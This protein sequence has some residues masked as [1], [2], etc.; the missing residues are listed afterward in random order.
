MMV[1]GLTG[2][3]GSGKST[4]ADQ[5]AALGVT[6]IDADKIS[7]ALCE[8]GE[9]GYQAIVEHFGATILE[10][11]GRINRRALRELTFGNDVE[12]QWLES[13]LHPLI[14]HEMDQQTKKAK[15]P[16]CMLVIPLL[17][18]S[19]NRDHIDRVLVIDAP[20]ELQLAR[21]CE[22]DHSNLE[23]IK[24]IMAAQNS[25]EERLSYADDVILNDS[26]LEHLQNE[27]AALHAAYLKM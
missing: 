25:R 4:V 17:T 9:L 3:I 16:Y 24:Q 6:I 20:E 10:S 2:G 18:E 21:A 11:S 14:R 27:V 23:Q 15:S 12:R 22:R 19:N 1:I 5:F 8:P 7:H 26:D 13:A